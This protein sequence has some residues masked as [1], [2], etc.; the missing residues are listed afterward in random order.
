MPQQILTAMLR[1]V[2]MSGVEPG[3]P[4]IGATAVDGNTGTR[5]SS[6]FADPQWVS[7]GLGTVH[8]ISRV[9]LTWET[10][11]GRTYRAETSAGGKRATAA[12]TTS[13]WPPKARYVRITG[14]QRGTQWGNVLT[15][16]AVG[17]GRLTAH[18]EVSVDQHRRPPTGG[19]VPSTIGT[20]VL[21]LPRDYLLPQ[22]RHLE[23][24]RSRILSRFDQGSLSW[25]HEGAYQGIASSTNRHRVCNDHRHVPHAGGT[26]HRHRR[27]P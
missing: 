27:R 14:A 12:P 2:T 20:A 17:P 16:G 22:P 8:R 15:V 6:A 7:V 9:R 10:A 13:R 25:L 23:T 18:R 26:R 24:A 11:Y 19:D 1:Q 21:G 3:T 5:W 4:H